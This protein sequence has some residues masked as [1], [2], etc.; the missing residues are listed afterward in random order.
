[1]KD[2]VKTVTIM[3]YC[4]ENNGKIIYSFDVLDKFD[5]PDEVL[6]LDMM[7]K[8]SRGYQST[9]KKYKQLWIKNTVLF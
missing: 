5:E 2:K 6:R 9:L 4:F 7:I 3:K 1:M 8:R